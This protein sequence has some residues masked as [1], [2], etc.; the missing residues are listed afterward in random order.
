MGHLTTAAWTFLVLRAA[1]LLPDWLAKWQ[2]LFVTR[3]DTQAQVQAGEGGAGVS[4]SARDD[5]QLATDVEPPVSGA[6]SSLA[7]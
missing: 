4:A 3:A 7:R 5:D 6:A 2:A 1:W